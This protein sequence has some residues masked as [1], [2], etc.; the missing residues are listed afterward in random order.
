MEKNVVPLTEEDLAMA[1]TNK[2]EI[3][4]EQ[5]KRRWQTNIQVLFVIHENQTLAKSK[6]AG[7]PYLD[8]T[9]LYTSG[10]GNGSKLTS[11]TLIASES[12]QS[13]KSCLKPCWSKKGFAELVHTSLRAMIWSN[14]ISQKWR[15]VA[16]FV[17]IFSVHS[18]FLVNI[19][20]SE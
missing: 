20:L 11:L 5:V 17:R 6:T 16:N 18:T 2:L 13:N 4:L 15:I 3:E 10:N 12:K 9:T 1:E 19:Y 14:Q 7:L 8:W